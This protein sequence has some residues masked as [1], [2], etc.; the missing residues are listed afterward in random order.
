MINRRMFIAST[1]ALL[2]SS[3]FSRLSQ[4]E[5]RP[6][7][8]RLVFGLPAGAMGSKLANGTLDILNTRFNAAYTLD[9]I[10]ARNTQKATETVKAARPDGTTLLQVQS[11]SMVL[12]P[13][14]YRSLNYDP[15]KDFTPL[16]VLGEYTFSLTLGPAVPAQVTDVDSYLAWV[17]A[18]P[19]FRDIGFTLYGSQSHLLSLMLA[20][21]KQIA[22]RPQPY[23]SPSS[24]VADLA[25]QTLAAAF[26]TPGNLE[27]LGDSK[28]IRVIAVSSATRL[29]QWP[30]AMTFAEQ[31]LGNLT[32]S[33]WYGWFAPAAMPQETARDLQQRLG[34][35]QA[36]DQFK[37]LQAS[38]LLTPANL[39]PAQINAR[40]TQETA[41]FQELVASYGLSKIT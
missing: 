15:S 32:M 33:G 30:L 37:Q 16:G 7:A 13:S 14:T 20:R 36:T 25:N 8:G 29:A 35:V 38:L 10:D 9:V 31:G 41:M 22:V 5:E 27:L 3:S 23:K 19:D 4:A 1:A 28:G 18:N 24:M 2:A 6:L 12:F 11:S 39:Q 26:T 21:E 40:M 34:D 17:S